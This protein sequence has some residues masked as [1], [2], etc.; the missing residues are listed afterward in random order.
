[1]E[2]RTRLIWIVGG[3]LIGTLIS[4]AFANNLIGILQAPLRD[5]DKMLIAISPTDTI[6]MFFKVSFTVGTVFAM[7]VIVYQI[8]AFVAPGL[9]P[10]EKRMLLLMLP[11]VM[12]LFACG[13]AF[14]YFVLLP[15][16]IGFLQGFLSEQVTQ[17]W[18]I[19][20]YIGFITRI[21]FWIGV[22]FEMPLVV[23]VLARIGLVS[24][25][26]LMGFW[27]QAVVIIAL[28]AAI[29]TPTVDP[30]NMA[31]V[32][33]PLGVLYLLSVGLAYMLYQPR[34]PRDFSVDEE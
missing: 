17:E 6:V 28:V 20:R 2:L 4:M 33:A 30:V 10:H 31:I 26:G 11:G 23:S 24:G 18:T 13:A 27:R 19:D 8:I 21:I 7:P 32:M 34:T 22:S 12:V 29:I 15:V 1:M 5:Y 14:A 9:Y 25:P 3:M 16:A